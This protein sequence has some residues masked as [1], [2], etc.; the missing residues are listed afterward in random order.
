[1][2]RGDRRRR[3]CW[4]RH[5]EPVPF[6]AQGQGDRAMDEIIRDG[7]VAGVIDVVTRGVGEELLGGNC[8]AAARTASGPRPRWGSL[9]SS[10]PAGSTCFR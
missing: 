7:M 6:H 1:M 3:I 8:A 4:P 2:S 5:F 10:R 9:K